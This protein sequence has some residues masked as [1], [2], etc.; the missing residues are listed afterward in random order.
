VLRR[1][2]AIASGLAAACRPAHEARPVPLF[3]GQDLTGWEGDPLLWLVENGVIVGRSPGIDYNDFLVTTA[4]FTN[5]ILRLQVQLVDNIGNSGI[6]FRSERVRG[7]MEM[8]GYQADI[9]EQYWAS[10]YDESR[11]RETLAA[12]DP[13]LLDSVLRPGDWNDYEIHANGPRLQL[14]LNGETTVDYTEPESDM[15][16]SGRIGLQIH[17]GPA[18]EV[19]FRNIE[20]QEIEP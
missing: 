1:C 15:A 14:K 3:N 17:S 16:L 9:G 19:R 6:Q 13:A 4:S 8:I 12:P 18:M 11:R 7:S 10:L 5:F 20:M 2:V